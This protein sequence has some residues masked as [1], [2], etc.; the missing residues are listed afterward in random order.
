MRFFLIPLAIAFVLTGCGG[1][2]GGK[3]TPKAGGIPLDIVPCDRPDLWPLSVRSAR[4]PIRVHYR[5]PGEAAA[6]AEVLFLLEQSWQVQIDELGF[7]APPSDG[8]ACGPDGD[9]DAFLWRGHEESFV[10]SIG[11]NPATPWDDAATY[12]VLDPWGPFGGPILDSTV[13]HELN[14]ACQAADDW[15]EIPLAFEATSQFVEDLTF[16]DDNEYRGLF[17]DFQARPDW[18]LTRGDDY[19]TYYMYGA[20]L[21]LFYLRD[22][23][24]LGDPSFISEVWFRSRNKPGKNEP[25]FEDALDGV[26][27]DAGKG[28]FYDSVVE[29]ARWRW[30][31]GARDDGR[32]FEEG[33]FFPEDATVAV[34]AEVE[35]R[36]RRV[37][38]DP[39]PMMLG[40]AY[41]DLV[42]APGGADA[43]AISLAPRPDARVRWVVQAL[44]GLDSTSDGETLDLSSGPATVFFTAGGRRTIVI[45]ALP[46]PGDDPDERTGERFPVTLVIE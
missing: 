22:G 8:G 46:E 21:Y 23:P 1:E 3:H 35:A 6:A 33:A 15:N 37:K 4:Y 41:V 11:E 40:S 19:E 13:A 18:S 16:D 12:L 30:Y 29:F 14:H 24:F 20:A 27:R 31:T 43:V 10:D 5:E 34:S 7:R 45:T 32:H 44:P 39:A 25:D 9:F 26:L 42:R 2:G 28:G 36:P 38:I 17:A